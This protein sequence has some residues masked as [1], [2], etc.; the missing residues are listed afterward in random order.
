MHPWLMAHGSLEPLYSGWLLEEG[1]IRRQVMAMAVCDLWSVFW[2]GDGIRKK[3]FLLL[4]SIPPLL[5][6]LEHLSYCHC[7]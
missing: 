3:V 5:F 1:A 2:G 7:C 4:F 6:C